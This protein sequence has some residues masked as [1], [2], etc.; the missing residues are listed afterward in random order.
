MLSDEACAS[1]GKAVVTSI[2][3]C[4]PALEQWPSFSDFGMLAAELKH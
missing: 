1:G 3:I 4:I 2:W